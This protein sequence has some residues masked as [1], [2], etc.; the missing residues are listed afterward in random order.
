MFG[1]WLDGIIKK[2]WK[3]RATNSRNIIGFCLYPLS[4]LVGAETFC[5]WMDTLAYW[6]AD[7]FGSN[8]T[9]DGMRH[10]RK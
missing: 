4:L 1:L 6:R 3:I 9:M 2:N 5:F 10:R 8:E 7:R